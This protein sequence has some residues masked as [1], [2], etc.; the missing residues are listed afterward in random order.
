MADFTFVEKR[1]MEGHEHALDADAVVGREGCE[2]V[3]PDPEVSRRHAALRKTASGAAVED[4]GSTNGT[5]VNGTRITG[6]VPIS[7]GDVVRFGNT[8][9]QLRATAAPA[10]AAGVGSPQ[11]TA[12]R[13]VP[14]EP[15]TSRAGGSSGAPGSARSSAR[16]LRPLRPLLRSPPPRRRSSATS[17]AR[18][19]PARAAAAT[20]R[21]RPR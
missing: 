9:W 21:C 13:S 7:E 4:L 14:V 6:L 20:C 1:P 11:V 16:R 3:L 5:F 12:A 18:A 2:V 17:S 10:A 8:E 15:V 19:C